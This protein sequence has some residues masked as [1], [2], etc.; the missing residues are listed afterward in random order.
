[1]SKAR[2]LYPNGG[3]DLGR[4]RRELPG[5]GHYAERPTPAF[6][7][8]LKQCDTV[9]GFK[10]CLTYHREERSQHHRWWLECDACPLHGS[11]HYGDTCPMLYAMN[12]DFWFTLTG[13]SRADVYTHSANGSVESRRT[14]RDSCIQAS[15]AAPQTPVAAAPVY[16]P[17]FAPP[18]AGV[19]TP[20]SDMAG[21]FP[22][23][24]FPA[25]NAWT[26]SANLACGVGVG[27][28]PQSPYLGYAPPPASSYDYGMPG[29]PHTAY[30]L[31]YQ[32]SYVPQAPVPPPASPR[33]P[34]SAGPGTVRF[35][36]RRANQH[37]RA[38]EEFDEERR[39]QRMKQQRT[40]EA[41][42]EMNDR[43]Q[44]RAKQL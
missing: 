31:P 21:Q 5:K 8:T 9:P 23:P 28:L 42:A 17:G 6:L 27:Y 39:Q 19:S 24:A 16:S 15:H 4:R 10:R 38:I 35:A 22:L 13:K 34:P 20:Y 44:S 12:D 2:Q 3:D 32:T 33:A 25:Y 14:A 7:Q 30:G 1:M 41:D 36:R 29:S 43:S 26:P 37:R 40:R 18:P 11:A